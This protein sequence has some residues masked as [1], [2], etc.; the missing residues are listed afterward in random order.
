MSRSPIGWT[1]LPPRYSPPLR[2]P[3]T[4]D[5]HMMVGQI[6]E[7]T[8]ATAEA[9][10]QMREDIGEIKE[11][12]AEGGEKFKTIEARL[13]EMKPHQPPPPPPPI[14]T[15]I[16]DALRY[17]IWIPVL[18]FTGSLEQAITMMDKLKAL[19]VLAAK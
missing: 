11:R 9:T 7:R 14:E 16:K 2:H 19:G 4:P 6:F 10:T 18:W 5:L 15:R 1:E 13:S 8:V 3:P 17:L 12:L